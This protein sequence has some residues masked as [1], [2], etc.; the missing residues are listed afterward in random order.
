MNKFQSKT[1][2]V[3][4]TFFLGAIMVS[5]ALTG[6]DGFNSSQG[7]VGTVD[8]EPITYTEYQNAYNQELTRF[9]Q[10][11][12]GKSLTNQQIRQFR[13]KEGVINRLVQ[14]K[15]ILNLAKDMNLDAGRKEI[16][17]EIKK[18]PY[19]LT[20]KK[21]D[22][23][24]YRALLAQNNFAPAKYEEL[25]SNDLATKKIS[26]IIGSLS[27][28]KGYIRDIQRF[29]K[30]TVTAN[31]VEVKKEML[32]KYVTVSDKE[33]RAFVQDKKNEKI[34]E[35]LFNSM[36]S[37]FNKP[38]R[39]EARHI[40]YKI[41]ADNKE[42]DVLK[43]A[44]ATKKRLTRSNFKQIAGKETQD[45]SGQG[46]KGGDLGWFTKGR[47]VPEFENAAFSM[48]K[49][50]ISEPIKT[51]Y[52]YH[53]IYVTDKEAAVEKKL[54]EV[55]NKVARNHLQKS[56]RKA[57]N[58]L[59]E[60]IKVKLE[61]AYKAGNYSEVSALARKY[62]FTHKPE[63]KVSQFDLSLDEVSLPVEK[64]KEIFTAKKDF[65]MEDTALIIAMAK[66]TKR[67]SDEEVKAAVE[68]A[69]ASEQEVASSGLTNQLQTDISKFLQDNAKVVTYPKLL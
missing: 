10:M 31:A 68:K 43:K 53:I 36:K 63:A 44:K 69:I 17:E 64:V 30:N 22:V 26:T 58:D 7:A 49:G 33:V 34:L 39:V 61:S 62:G 47:M 9:S 12:G 52:G 56:N 35:G 25:I 1:S 66:V 51:S 54:S 5:F 46:A 20:D 2:Y 3:I 45:P 59:V 24:K 67:M 55:Q 6:F 15:L 28:S 18:T 23:R 42:A 40:L 38:A 57:L 50:S 29:K 14:Q 41:D 13:I 27:P 32:T 11:F 16:K 8:G 37:E 4:I 65:V 48:E 21:F 60:S 19:F